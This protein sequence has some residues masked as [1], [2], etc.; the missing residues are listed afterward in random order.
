MF[1]MAKV[2]DNNSE[3]YDVEGRRL[4]VNSTTG[5]KS[6]TMLAETKWEAGA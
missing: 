4:T 3:V 2:S 1:W 6:G 5:E